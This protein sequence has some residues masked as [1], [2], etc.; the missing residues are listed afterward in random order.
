M[1]FTMEVIIGSQYLYFVHR[2]SSLVEDKQY[3]V[4]NNK[5]IISFFTLS[6]HF[7]K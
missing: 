3:S 7:E 4:L 1:C 2:S 5:S 6:R